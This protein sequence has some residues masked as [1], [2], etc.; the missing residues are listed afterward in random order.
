MHEECSVHS[1]SAVYSALFTSDMRI[2][3][4]HSI[5]HELREILECYSSV[6]S[7]KTNEEKTVFVCFLSIC[8]AYNHLLNTFQSNANKKNNGMQPYLYLCF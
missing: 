3:R 7:P 1:G 4:D 8:C 6:S 2:F 5:C